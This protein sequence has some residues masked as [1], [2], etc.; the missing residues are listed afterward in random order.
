MRNLIGNFHGILFFCCAFFAA[1]K[2][3]AATRFSPKPSAYSAT[4]GLNTRSKAFFSQEYYYQ[5]SWLIAGAL[6]WNLAGRGARLMTRLGYE[7]FAPLPRNKSQIGISFGESRLAL[8][9]GFEYQRDLLFG[10]SSGGLKVTKESHLEVG[11]YITDQSGDRSWQEA[12]NAPFAKVWIGVPMIPETL[13]LSLTLQRAFF[14][15]PDDERTNMGVELRYE[16]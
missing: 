14:S 2:A 11:D 16:Y 10:I 13:L 4:L 5:E 7:K 9:A 6:H 15:K 3:S 1:G 12:F 8:E